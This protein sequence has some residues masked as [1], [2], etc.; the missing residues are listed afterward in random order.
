MREILYVAFDS[1]LALVEAMRVPTVP[2]FENKLTHILLIC[3]E[4][5][6]RI[7]IEVLL[8]CCHEDHLM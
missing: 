8:R 5:V 4:L 2:A 6:C 7:E 1:E 3:T